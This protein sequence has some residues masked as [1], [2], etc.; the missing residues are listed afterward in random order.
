MTAVIRFADAVLQA[1]RVQPPYML[2][3]GDIPDIMMSSS[4]R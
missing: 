4:M 1:A 2:W 3:R